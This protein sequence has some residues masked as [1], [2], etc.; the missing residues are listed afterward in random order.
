MIM[1]S[2]C[3]ATWRCLL[4]TKVKLHQNSNGFISQETLRRNVLRFQY[5]MNSWANEKSLEIC[6][7]L[8]GFC[9]QINC[10]ILLWVAPRL[11]K[12]LYYTI[13]QIKLFLGTIHSFQLYIWQF[14][15]YLCGRQKAKIK[16]RIDKDTVIKLQ[17]DWSNKAGL[18]KP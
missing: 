2:I 14:I 12:L 6:R 9:S 5:Q 7:D 11:Q 13:T 1:L 17:F 3:W 16:N 4:Y 8:Q 10:L 15:R 18:V